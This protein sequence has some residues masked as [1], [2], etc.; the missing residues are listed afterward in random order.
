MSD[1]RQ[2]SYGRQ[3]EVSDI[4]RLFTAGRNVSMHGPRRLGKTFLLDRIVEGAG[5]HGWVALKVELA[6]CTDSRAVFREFC[7]RIGSSK[8]GGARAKAWIQQRLTQFL[9][10][11]AEGG[12][13]WFQP[14]I[15]LDHEAY[16]ERL[17]QAMNEDPESEWALLIDELPIFLKALHDRGDKGVIDAR[18][19]MNLLV[20][21][22]QQYPKVRWMITGSIGI[23]PLAKAGNYMG[24][25]AKFCSFELK[26]LSVE[27][28]MDYVQ[29]IA[30]DGCLLNRIEITEAEAQELVN[31]V[32]WRAPFYIDALAQKLEGPAE[33]EGVH[34]RAAVE[35]A[36][37][38][39]V[40]VNEM[41]VFGTWEEHLRKHYSETEGKIAFISLNV[42]CR[43]PGATDIDVLLSAIGDPSL[44][45]DTLRAVLM[46][47]STEGFV[48]VD[49]WESEI[50]TCNFL[51]PLLRRWWLLARPQYKL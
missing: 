11:R 6:G 37:R 51:N 33:T 30:A 4:F 16:F 18:D 41:V 21:M 45:K 49:D 9:S 1:Y 13:A 3:V 23:E 20:R 12:G 25:L 39:L 7:N 17:I 2:K 46:R 35:S 27:Q 19:F 28:A 15:S 36:V 26:P 40:T 10:P 14:F 5:D 48:A 22:Q 44:S 50:P 31:A 24:V 47:L 8:T 38:R 29:D 42:I 43:Q 34:A 32:G